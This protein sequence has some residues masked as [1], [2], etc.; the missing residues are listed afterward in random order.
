MDN[1]MP[2]IV[3]DFSQ[4]HSVRRVVLGEAIGTL[5]TG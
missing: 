2:I 1:R 4:P 3:F 5:V